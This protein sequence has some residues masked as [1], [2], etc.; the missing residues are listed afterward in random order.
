MAPT[1][2]ERDTRAPQLR[3]RSVPDSQLNFRGG[4]VQFNFD[5][6]VEVS[7][8]SSELTITPLTKVLPKVSAG[9]KSISITIPDSILTPNTTYLV[10]FGKSIKDINEGNVAETIKFTFSTG[11]FFDSLSIEGTIYEAET[12]KPDTAAKLLL[13][14]AQSSDSAFFKEKPMYISKALDGQFK[15]LNLPA[16]PFKLFAL[17]ENNPNLKYDANGERIGFQSEVLVAGTSKNSIIYTFVEASNGDTASKKIVGRNGNMIDKNTTLTYSVKVDTNIKNRSLDISKPLEINISRAINKYDETKIRLFNNN[18]LD[19]TTQLQLDSNK[20]TLLLQA[21]WQQDAVYEL[22]L[23]KGFA[24][25]S[26]AGITKS[27]TISFRTL[28][29]S[30]YGFITILCEKNETNYVELLKDELVLQRKA[31]RDTTLSFTKLLPGTYNIRVLKDKNNN[32][33]WDTGDLHLKRQ[34]EIV[35]FIPSP[36]TIKANWEQKLDIRNKRSAT[37]R[38]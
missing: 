25:D 7:N 26:T 23:L 24:S 18:I 9:K 37:N 13:Y 30:D 27:D 15:F 21:D 4:V 14:D 5:E 16:R 34:P 31:C 35:E 10:D 33:I 29:N 11:S 12:G 19:A 17:K 8:V 1:G 2:G 32:G 28:K 36:I 38:N 20:K 6:W 3:S 22:H